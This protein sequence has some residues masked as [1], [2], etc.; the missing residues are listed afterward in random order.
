MSQLLHLA[1]PEDLD[2][3][4][5]MVERFHGEAGIDSDAEHR[6]TAV[7]PLLDGSPLGAIWLIGPRMA[8]VGYVCVS[9]GWSL[10]LGGMDGFI[11]ELWIRPK[12][13]G[14]GMGSDA[15]AA[16]QG[17]L[18]EVGVRALHLE[19]ARTNAGAERIYKRAGFHER[20]SNLM[21]WHPG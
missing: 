1:A 4:T 2:R 14:R 12:V 9:F 15:L 20:P 3:V 5:S 21:T 11:D 6:E 7:R 19:V 16:L 13:R 18:H 10:E 17:T 8:P